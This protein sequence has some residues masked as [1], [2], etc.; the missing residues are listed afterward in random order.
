MIDFER[1][2]KLQSYLDGELSAKEAQAVADWLTRD[3]EAAALLG[4]LRQT[5]QALVGFER[6]IQ[7]P[8]SRE[9]YWS[10]IQREILRGEAATAKPRQGIP[11]WLGRLRRLLI[12][13]ASVAAVLLVAL[14]IVQSPSRT[15]GSETSLDDSGAFTFHDFTAGTTLV[16]LTYPAEAEV[17]QNEDWDTLD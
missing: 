5:S 15:R 1:Q 17:A 8:E 11:Q 6:A 9:F 12:P 14:T 2:L 10:K 16:W 7:L 13:A 3:E 4:E